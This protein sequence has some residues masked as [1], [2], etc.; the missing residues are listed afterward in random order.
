ME[1]NLLVLPIMKSEKEIEILDKPF[2]K[3]LEKYGLNRDKLAEYMAVFEIKDTKH[4]G[5]RLS[6]RKINIK[7]E[8][9]KYAEQVTT[10]KIPRFLMMLK[11]IGCSINEL[12]LTLKLDE[13]TN[14]NTK[15]LLLTLPLDAKKMNDNDIQFIKEGYPYK[16]LYVNCDFTFNVSERWLKLVKRYEIQCYKNGLTKF[17]D[18][19]THNVKG[20]PGSMNCRDSDQVL[21]NG[22]SANHSTVE[23]PTKM[24]RG[25]VA[26][27]IV[28]FFCPK[29]DIRDSRC[30]TTRVSNPTDLLQI[31][32][33]L[34]GLDGSNIVKFYQYQ[35][36]CSHSEDAE[37]ISKENIFLDENSSFKI[38]KDKPDLDTVWQI[39]WSESMVELE[40]IS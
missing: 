11:L 20:E 24:Y 23:H 22:S 33:K 40:R 31:R 14:Y 7:T 2:D 18:L 30:Y 38:D 26:E 36:S 1:K 3:L 34:I 13:D 12:L 21:V 25:D 8:L 16:L 32:A 29:V 27:V 5:Y 17:Q 9:K 19:L 35:N 6:R 10:P 39:D 37:P 4:N 15:E 28:D